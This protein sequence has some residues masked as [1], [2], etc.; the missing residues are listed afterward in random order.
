MSVCAACGLHLASDDALCPHHHCLY[1][2]DWA[3]ANRIQCDFF[4]RGKVPVRLNETDR[5]DDFWGAA[6]AGAF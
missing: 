5:A 2:D 1:G 6:D 4:H 3:V